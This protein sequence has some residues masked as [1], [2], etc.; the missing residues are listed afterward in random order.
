MVSP[1]LLIWLIAYTLLLGL[2]A[3][4]FALMPY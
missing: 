3:A 1:R 4:V 2:A